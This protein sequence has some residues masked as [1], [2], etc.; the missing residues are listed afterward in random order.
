LLPQGEV[1]DVAELLIKRHREG[2]QEV[3][4]HTVFQQV[5]PKDLPLE[6]FIGE[7]YSHRGGWGK[8]PLKLLEV[9]CVLLSEIGTQ[10][11]LPLVSSLESQCQTLKCLFHLCLY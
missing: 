3:A 7:Q 11:L 5:L 4:L 10:P 1:G 2:S 6:I 8:I 9:G